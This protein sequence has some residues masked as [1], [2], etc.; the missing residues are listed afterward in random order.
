[1]RILFF[2]ILF[3]NI[4]LVRICRNKRRTNTSYYQMLTT[5]QCLDGF[6]VEKTHTWEKGY[7]GKL[8]LD[9][10]W[11][12]KP[13]EDW[14]LDLG[15]CNQVEEFKVWSANIVNPTTASNLVKNVEAVN[16]S[17]VCWNGILYSCQTW[18]L[19][20]LVRFPISSPS[21]SADYDVE[22]VSQHVT[23]GDGSVSTQTFCPASCSPPTTST[24]QE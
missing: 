23:L 4:W 13:T 17:N 14:L 16:I 5:A 2:A 6:T 3:N 10:S 9:Q 20:F 11:L 24:R 15:F 12:S 19:S 21:N 1:M 18:E 8:V 7:I 22:T